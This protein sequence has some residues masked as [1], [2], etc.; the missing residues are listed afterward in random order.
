MII[1]KGFGILIIPLFGIAMILGIVAGT[2]LKIPG[3]FV[4]GIVLAT[5]LNHVVWLRL[6]PKP[7]HADSPP[8]RKHSLFFIPA[9]AWTWIFALL[10]L[11]VCGLEYLAIQGE[12][13]LAATP[14]YAEFQEANRKIFSSKSGNYHGNNDKATEAAR[15]YSMI[16]QVTC[17]AIFTGGSEKPFLTKGE[18]LTY[19]H[20]GK[21]TV[22][23]LCHVPDLRK[24]A[25]DKTKEAL[26]STA[27]TLARLS[28]ADLGIGEDPKVV[29]GLRGAVDYGFILHGQASTETPLRST[30]FRRPDIFFRIFAE[31]TSG[32][33]PD[34]PT[35]TS[36]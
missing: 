22:L 5:L 10:I 15:G 18:F 11:P 35:A 30:T 25:D 7:V 24:Y 28:A 1:W 3:G 29:V 27:W 32:T 34:S 6:S 17:E 16:M 8:P 14:G 12:K 9:K 33:T 20:L 36:P 31:T 21:D 26:V 23:Y 19:C 13:D 2:A 4:L